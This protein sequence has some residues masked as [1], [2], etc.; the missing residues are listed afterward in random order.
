MIYP[1]LRG[2]N[3]FLQIPS[4]YCIRMDAV[5]EYASVNTNPFYNI[6]YG[7]FTVVS[8][9]NIIGRSFGT[10]YGNYLRKQDP[11][12]GNKGFMFGL[13]N[14]AGAPRPLIIMRQS[15]NPDVR[16]A[17]YGSNLNFVHGNWNTV[18]SGRR[19]TDNATAISASSYFMRL[20]GFNGTVAAFGN[21]G[22]GPVTDGNVDNNG[23]LLFGGAG[24][25]GVKGYI[26]LLAFY[27]RAFTADEM[28][29]ADAGRL[30]SI[31]AKGIWPFNEGVGTSIKD[32]S[33]V[34][35]NASLVGYTQEETEH[36]TRSAWVREVGVMVFR[37]AGNTAV[38]TA[39][40]NLILITVRRFN[41]TGGTFEYS[42]D[43]ATWVNIQFTGDIS[44]VNIPLTQ[45][46][47]LHLRSVVWGAPTSEFCAIELDW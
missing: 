32:L 23:P 38:F 1:V 44:A 34:G 8:R 25:Q 3:R 47:S 46:Q 20:N 12:A 45:G 24:Q 26:S 40:E 4:G 11:A 43:N 33:S 31:S 13:F 39:P 27:A 28:I 21:G 17:M 15:S 10:D 22:G 5:T 30:S 18:I 14:T 29:Q 16:L 6:G 9:I 37:A 42:L 35:G 2:R 19:S 36:P 7:P 41:T